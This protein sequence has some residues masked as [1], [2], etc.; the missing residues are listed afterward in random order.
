VDLGATVTS[1]SNPAVKAAR[2]LARGSG[3]RGE[4]SSWRGRR[5]S[6]RAC[7]PRAPVRDGG[8]RRSVGTSSRALP[9]A[10]A[11]VVAVSPR[12]SPRWR[13]R[14]PAGPRRRG[15]AARRRPGRRV[16]GCEPR[17]RLLG[18]PRPRQRRHHH[19]DGRRGRRGRGRAHRRQ[20]RP[21][22]PQ[23]R[24]RLGRV[25]VPPAR[26]RGA[27]LAE[28]AGACRGAGLRLVAA[29]AAGAV[30][31]TDLDLAAPTALV[32]G[33]E[34]RG[35]PPEVRASCDLVARV[36]IHGGRSRSTSPHRR[37]PGLRGGPPARRRPRMSTELRGSAL[38]TRSTCC[39]TRPSWSAPTG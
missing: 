34:A 17:R 6:A 28:V 9:N 19:P 22:Q 4:A 29:D 35:L 8:G 5:P 20:R 31:H 3:R 12:S 36:P 7:P 18:G 32:L 15:G 10:G 16:A 39:R 13:D 27:G 11:Q 21:A 2:K 33:N 37:R 38:E 26:R 25:A 24:P 23:G 1:A 30:L 14:H